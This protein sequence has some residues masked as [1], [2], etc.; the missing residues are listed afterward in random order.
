MSIKFVKVQRNIHTGANPGTRYLARI[1]RVSNITT[2]K[3]AV[4]I[5]EATTVSAPD[6][7]A[8]LKALE[9]IVSR[10]ILN[11][12]AVKLDILGMFA[13]GIKATAKTTL[14]QVDASTIKRAYC[15]FYPSP[16]FMKQLA[17]ASFEEANLD[18][19]GLQS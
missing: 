16:D 13:P 15:R 1:F 5:S 18:I 8:A 3:L 19:T 6:V 2:E 9:I 7:L 11:G 4:E 17:K 14:A 12:E 10:H